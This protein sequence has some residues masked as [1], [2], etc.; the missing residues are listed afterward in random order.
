MHLPISQNPLPR[1]TLN[2]WSHHQRNQELVLEE[3]G[4]ASDSALS[5]GP[6]LLL[7]QPVPLSSST[8]HK[9]AS[10]THLLLQDLD[11]S[12][13]CSQLCWLRLV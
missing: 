2:F 10:S 1:P 13:G 5:G 7:S 3:G 9:H 4:G 8:E 11:L 12:R 6:P